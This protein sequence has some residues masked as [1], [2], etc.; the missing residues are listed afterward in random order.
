M[1]ECP[2]PLTGSEEFA[3]LNLKAPDA[4]GAS[5]YRALYDL[6]SDSFD[7]DDEPMGEWIADE[8]KA[9]AHAIL[10]EVIEWAQNLKRQIDNGNG[11]GSLI[12]D[13]LGGS[14]GD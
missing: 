10:D 3:A 9:F 1:E 5:E 12:P 4:V 7:T 13:N 2:K 14:N 8:P 11:D 6:L